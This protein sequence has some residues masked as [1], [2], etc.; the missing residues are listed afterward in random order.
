M[1][2]EHIRHEGLS[3]EGDERSLSD[4]DRS[5]YPTH[6]PDGVTETLKDEGTCQTSVQTQLRFP[7]PRLLIVLFVMSV[8]LSASSQGCFLLLRTCSCYSPWKPV[9]G[10]FVHLPSLLDIRA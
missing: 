2:T 3:K 6:F 10:Y 8:C 1:Y 4:Y 9:L 7:P 5:L